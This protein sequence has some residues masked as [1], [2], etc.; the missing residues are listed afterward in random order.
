MIFASVGSMLPF[1]RMVNEIDLWAMEN[2]QVPVFIQIGDGQRIP[3]HCE[4]VRSLSFADYRRNLESSRLF[5]AHAGMGSIIQAFELRKPII[6]FPRRGSLNEH[7]N[8]HQLDTCTRFR[9]KPGVLIAYDETTLR[10]H[11]AALVDDPSVVPVIVSDFADERL[12]TEL[13]NFLR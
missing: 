3:Q 10:E 1:D 13:R 8:D 4:W 2:P 6:L 12:L 11:L 7:V 9:D 5:V